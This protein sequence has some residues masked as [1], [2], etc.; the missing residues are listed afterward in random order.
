MIVSIFTDASY[1]NFNKTGAFAYVLKYKNDCK[2]RAEMITAPL[3][4]CH[5]AEAVAIYE[6]I[7]DAAESYDCKL[8]FVK[9]DSLFVVRY[10]TGEVNY[11]TKDIL[12]DTYL[13]IRRKISEHGLILRIKHIKAHTG[14]QDPASL[15][16]EWC[17]KAAYYVNTNKKISTQSN[18][19]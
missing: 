9:S 8:L 4:N 10:L 13:K 12:L 19:P 7:C 14:K 2:Y 16:N 17:D 3:L 6:A 5:H 18:K 1:D 15:I 11:Q